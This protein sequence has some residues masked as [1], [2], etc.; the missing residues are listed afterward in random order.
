MIR[1]ERLTVKASEALQ[2][3]SQLASSRGNPVVNDAHLFLALLDQDE[4]IVIPVLQKAGLNVTELREEIERELGRLP[5]QSGEAGTQPVMSRE[6]SA[7]L[8]RADALAKDLGRVRL[9]RTPA[10][11]VGGHQ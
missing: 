7:A 5:Q 11:R 6:L 9:D 10:A 3:A 8:D 1:P 2:L 4:G